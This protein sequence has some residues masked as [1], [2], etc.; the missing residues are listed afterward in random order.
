M[1]FV[2]TGAGGFLGSS[3]VRELLT[4]TDHDV[5]AVS[6]QT[7]G[8]LAAQLERAPYPPLRRFPQV[9]PRT[10]LLEAGFLRD[11]DV[12]VDLLVADERWLT[13]LLLRLA[14]N[15]SVTSPATAGAGLTAAA[16]AALALYR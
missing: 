8:E 3:V 10:R 11:A 7:D 12:E 9:H 16:Q 13:K 4:E 15:A 14:P 6:S 5:V 2:V 1:R